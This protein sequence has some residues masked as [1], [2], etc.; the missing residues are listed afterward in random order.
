MH[1]THHVT[2]A[3]RVQRRADAGRGCKAGA[4]VHPRPQ[5]AAAH[6]CVSE[7]CILNTH[8]CTH[9]HTYILIMCTHACSTHARNHYM[10]TCEQL[11]T[12]AA[13]A[14][15]LAPRGGNDAEEGGEVGRTRTRTF[16]LG[17]LLRMPCSRARSIAATSGSSTSP[18]SSAFWLPG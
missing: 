12:A 4:A 5:P 3:A 1:K 11:S 18:A 10:H 13:H 14:A 16:M 9:V 17:L 6:M 2:E 8:T 15:S 7:T